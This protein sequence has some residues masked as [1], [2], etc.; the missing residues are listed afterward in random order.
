MTK[1]TAIHISGENRAVDLVALNVAF[2]SWADHLCLNGDLKARS[3]GLLCFY[4]GPC[5]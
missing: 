5:V 2:G 3:I 4:M 1:M